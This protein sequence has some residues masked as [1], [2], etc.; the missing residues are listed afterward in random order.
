VLRTEANLTYEFFAIRAGSA[1]NI[2][3]LTLN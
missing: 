1:V 2:L 3:T